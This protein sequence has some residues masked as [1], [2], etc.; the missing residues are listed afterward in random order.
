MPL[1]SVAKTLILAALG[2]LLAG[3]ALYGVAKL[4]LPRL[5][6]DLVLEGRHWKVT[7]PLATSILVSL[8]LTV[9]LNLALRFFR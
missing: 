6:G 4:G 2:L 5:P 9:L 8:L 3:L 1:E 7:F